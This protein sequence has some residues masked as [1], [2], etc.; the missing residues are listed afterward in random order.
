MSGSRE[1]R[2]AEIAAKVAEAKQDSDDLAVI[3]SKLPQGAAKQLYKDS[4]AAE[5]LARHGIAGD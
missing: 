2:I 4:E 3:L 1:A 5:I